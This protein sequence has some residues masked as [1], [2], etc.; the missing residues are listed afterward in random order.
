MNKRIVIPIVLISMVGG[1]FIYANSLENKTISNQ[2]S[3][4]QSNAQK[5]GVEF[6]YKNF[7]SSLLSPDITINDLSFSSKNIPS[8]MHI[9]SVRIDKDSFNKTK[10]G[11]RPN[12]GITIT[13]F[14]TEEKNSLL[15]NEVSLS[16]NYAYNE[17]THSINSDF[18]IDATNFGNLSFKINL[19]NAESIW[20]ASIKELQSKLNGTPTPTISSNDDFKNLLKNTELKHFNLK[21]ED[22]GLITF[23]LNMFS[24]GQN[25][26]LK[27]QIINQI[28]SSFDL[29]S[30]NKIKISSFINNPKTFEINADPTKPVEL[31]KT[32][33][34]IDQSKTK[35]PFSDLS[36]K[37]NVSFDFIS[38]KTIEQKDVVP[39][40]KK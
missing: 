24:N 4:L 37:L 34:E 26:A 11:M 10:D 16:Y 20:N 30:E 18:N 15:N 35:T 3:E 5:N 17:V 38:S 6:T 19:L 28:N 12:F 25:Q 7:E 1:G 36:K 27:D 39:L 14:K 31:F 23:V 33:N 32:L 2:I 29:S 40:S 9:E 21:Y 8:K 13:K 22:K